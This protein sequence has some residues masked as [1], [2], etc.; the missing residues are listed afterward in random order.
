MSL[1]GSL[2]IGNSALTASQLAIQ[3][4]GNNLANAATPGYTRQLALLQPA[5]GDHSR[6]GMS[7]GQGVRV[8]DVQRQI[9]QALQSRLWAGVS[10]EAS[11]DQA[12]R[13]LGQL[14]STLNE[15][16]GNDVSSELSAFFN[17]WSERANLT[18]SSAAVVQQG[19]RL[20][21]FMQRVRSDLL[22]Q[23]GQ[24]DRQIGSMV[25]RADALL[26]E[27]AGLNAEVARA[28]TSGGRA[29]DLRD[30]RDALV[31]ELSQYLDVSV[32]EQPTGSID[33]LVGSTPV[34]LGGRSRGL[35]VRRESVNGRLEVSVAVRDD[36]Q[37][38]PLTSGRL[39]AM[40]QARAE[41]IDRTVE[42]LDAVASELIFQVNRVH[43]TGTNTRGLTTTT[44]SLAV[45]SA[46]RTLALNDPANATLGGLP[47]SAVNGGFL[48][49][50]KQS[51]TGSVDEVYI[52]VDLD[53]RDAT[54]AVGF[55]NDTSAEDIRTALNAVTGLNASFTADGKL[56][57]SADPGFEFSF[58]DDSSGAL[59]VLGVNSY[60]TG[61][62]ASDIGVRQ[63][64]K[65][66][67]GALAAGRIV[68][69]AF[70]ENA[71]ALEVAGL[72]DRSLTALGDR[73]LRAAWTDEVQRIGVETQAAAT[74]ADAAMLV[75]ESLDAQRA[76]VSG[77]S[78]DEESVNLLTFQRQYQG[79]ARFISV[80]DE[81]TR[82]LISIV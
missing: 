36:G 81:L 5:R 59:A 56:R 82:T 67:P 68:N 61:S 14:E 46:D 57:V 79:A 69:G 80:V 34:L 50:V 71:T 70:V 44:G 53:G 20:A 47:F 16:S 52:R 49:R 7:V 65:D 32:V 30:R 51:A 37:K 35:E 55:G 23:R 40:L 31:T 22:G 66:A 76:A 54:G 17:V 9:D 12:L 33:I 25:V 24:I 48:V 6:P 4:T 27:I 29:N 28:E 77:V 41:G 1:T 2:Q 26:T 60:F 73:T 42:R 19:E 58:G 63:A 38:L 15:L 43:S 18:Q 78:I 74:R 39:G 62:N 72:Q 64:L 3:V 13:L 45:A 75:R 21:Q 8:R 10:H 11:S